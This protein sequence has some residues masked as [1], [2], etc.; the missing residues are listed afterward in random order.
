MFG[1]GA[2]SPALDWREVRPESLPVV[3][4]F[5]CK[6]A[7]HARFLALA[8]AT[9]KLTVLACRT[10]NAT[11]AV[12]FADLVDPARVSAAIQELRAAAAANI[13]AE[14]APVN[15]WNVVGATPN[16]VA[17]RSELTGR[18]PD[19]KPL[20]MH[21][22]LFALGTAVAQLSVLGKAPGREGVA[23][24]FGGVAAGK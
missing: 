9:V 6:P 2:C 12:S 21:M 11:W 23:A 8:G 17:G 1:L 20:Q 13:S 15:E 4:L 22:G 18:Y 3:V 19:G 7:S 16:V 14:P 10:G 24:F 5:P